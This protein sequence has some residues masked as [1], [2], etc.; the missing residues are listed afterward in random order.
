MTRRFRLPIDVPSFALNPVIMKLFSFG[1]LHSQWNDRVHRT[2]G[3]NGAGSDDGL[4][5]PDLLGLD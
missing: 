2:V 3:A 4:I 5:E 1:I